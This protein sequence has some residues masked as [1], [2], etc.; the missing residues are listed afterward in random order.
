MHRPPAHERLLMNGHFKDIANNFFDEGSPYFAHPLLTPERTSSEVDQVLEGQSNLR[1][2]DI[3]CGFG[4]HSIELA[5]RGCDVVGVDPSAAMIE[6]AERRADDA[7]LQI[8]FRHTSGGDIDDINRF[9]LALCLFT[10]L[11]QQGVDHAD[12]DQASRTLLQA[13]FTS[14]TPGGRLV[15]EVPERARAIAA[16]LPEEHL[17]P[18]GNKTRVTRYFDPDTN[19]VHERFEPESTDRTFDLSFRLFSRS[20]L[21]AEIAAAGFVD[22]EVIDRALVPPPPTFITVLAT[23]PTG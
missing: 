10:T 14:L 20:E 2:L 22:L 13:A 11:G 17:G 3:G 5:R 21:E 12:P 18:E 19:V 23:C 4:R 8:E 7:G 6:E 16:L 9:D 15:V 1:V